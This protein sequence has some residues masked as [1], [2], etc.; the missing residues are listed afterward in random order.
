VPEEGSGEERKIVNSSGWLKGQAVVRLVLG[1]ILIGVAGLAGCAKSQG[2][3]RTSAP[4]AEE[5]AYLQ[6]IEIKSA[7]MTAASNFLGQE[8]FT[9]NAEVTNR[10]PK[11]VRSLR[12]EMEF[13][14]IMKQKTVLDKIVQPITSAEPP[15]KPGETRAISVSF[16]NMPDE[17]NQGPP[18]IV[19]VS[20]GF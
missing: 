18:R 3:G 15:L 13:M 9:L 1:F 11:V 2:E 14:D 19:P 12:L 20:V 8:V 7:H 16:E 6:Q 10:G 17:W 5:K 4:G